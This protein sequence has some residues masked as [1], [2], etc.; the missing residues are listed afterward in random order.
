M[1]TE[2]LENNELFGKS[3]GNKARTQARS[4]LSNAVQGL[5]TAMRVVEADGLYTREEIEQYVLRTMRRFEETL[6]AMDVEEF[7]AYLDIQISNV[8]ARRRAK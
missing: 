2:R 4:L 3:D 8:L 1:L 5:V 7:D 6:Y